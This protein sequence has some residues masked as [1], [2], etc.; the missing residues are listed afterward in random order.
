M[1]IFGKHNQQI[2]ETNVHEK[3]IWNDEKKNNSSC[4]IVTIAFQIQIDP[5]GQRIITQRLV[6]RNW[7]FHHKI[8]F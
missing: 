8:K 3:N 2:N 1:Y 4:N 6:G 5:I 7:G